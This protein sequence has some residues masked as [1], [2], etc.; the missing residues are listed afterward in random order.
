MSNTK[1]VAQ[2]HPRVIMGFRQFFDGYLDYCLDLPFNYEKTSIS[3]ERG[4]QFALLYGKNKPAYDKH[5]K[6]LP[7]AVQAFKSYL[8]EKI[9][10]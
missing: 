3:Y 1:L 5:G 2:T 8:R 6:P 4:R 9:I 10:I 7:A